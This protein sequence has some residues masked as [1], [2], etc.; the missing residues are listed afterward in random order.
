MNEKLKEIYNSIIKKILKLTNKSSF[1]YEDLAIKIP[2]VYSHSLILEVIN[3]FKNFNVNAVPVV[4]LDNEVVGIVTEREI[5]Q[6]IALQSLSGWSDLKNY[7][8]SS[9]ILDTFNTISTSATLEEM[10]VEFNDKH[11]ELLILVNDN[12]VYSDYCI[13]HASLTRY[14]YDSI[15]P[16]SIGGLATP[17]GVYLTDGYYNSGPGF[18][19]LFLTG[20]TLSIVLNIIYFLSFFLFEHFQMSQTILLVT[21]LFLYIILLRLSPLVGVH[22]AEHQTVHAMEKGIE[23]TLENVKQQPKEHH[24]CGSNLMVLL[25]GISVLTTIYFDYLSTFSLP[26]K[27]VFIILFTFV[28]FSTWKKA[29]MLLQKFLTTAKATDKQLMNAIKSG[30]QLLDFY[31]NNTHPI[32]VTIYHKIWNMGIIQVLFTFLIVSI[33]IQFI[34]CSL[35][36]HLFEYGTILLFNT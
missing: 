14:T 1:D 32:K 22:A 25:L 19:G 11:L 3:I 28:L 8:V 31:K 21:Q 7:M 2:A 30:Q 33:I 9:V 35:W 15:K 18:L 4:N 29:G 17:I 10:V 34:V 13:T 5:T 23:L 16:R 27:S 6:L 12:N 20:I 24:R 36:P 26:E